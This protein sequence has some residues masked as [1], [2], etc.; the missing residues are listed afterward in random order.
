MKCK[1]GFDARGSKDIEEYAGVS[2]CVLP[3]K[4]CTPYNERRLENAKRHGSQDG[5]AKSAKESSI[6]C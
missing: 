1:C 3:A 2:K 6:T 5:V 4:T